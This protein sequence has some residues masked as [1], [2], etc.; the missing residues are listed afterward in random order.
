MESSNPDLA[1]VESE[2]NRVAQ[3]AVKALKRSRQRCLSAASGVPTWTGV[4]G[5]SGLSEPPPKRYGCVFDFVLRKLFV[6]ISTYRFSV[7]SNLFA[8]S[9]LLVCDSIQLY[10]LL[11]LCDAKQQ[12]SVVQRVD[13]VIHWIS[14]YTVDEIFRKNSICNLMSLMPN[15]GDGI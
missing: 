2:A 15:E 13:S 4:S 1:L 3:S 6:L 14:C 5:S 8:N 10:R 11:S 7:L 9:K 12:A